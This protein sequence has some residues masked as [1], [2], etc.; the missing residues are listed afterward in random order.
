MPAAIVPILIAWGANAVVAYV[1]AYAITIVATAIISKALFSPSQPD[2]GG[3]GA[4]QAQ[5][6]P[7][8]RQQIPPATDNKLPVVYGDAYIGGITVDLSISSNNQELYYVL[9]L[10]EVTSTNTGQTPD[11]FT[12]G[13]VYYGGKKVN[14]QSDGYTVASLLDESTGTTDTAVAGKIQFYLYSN[15]SYAPVN[16]TINAVTVMSNSDLIYKWDSS[17]LMTNCAFAIIHLS[18]NNDAGITGIEQTRFEVKNPLKKPGDVI[19]DYL[20]NTR[21]GGAIPDDQIDTDSLDALNV[22][23]DELMT[24]TPYSGGSATQKRFEF[25]GTVV[26]TR[27][28]MQNLQDMTSCCDCL[29]KYNEIMGLWGVIVQSPSYVVSMDINDSNMIS[30]I[31]VSPVDIANSFNIAQVN[32]PDSANQDTF[33]SSTFDLAQIDPELLYPNE[34][35][36]QQ[37]ITLP[38]VNNDV[39]AQ[40][41]A[42]RFL[43]SAREDL[44]VQTS[45]NFVGIQLEA[46]DIVTLTNANYGWVAKLFRVG[47]V[48]ETFGDDGTVTAVLALLEFNPT[49]YDDVSITQFNPSPNTGLASPSF[50]GAIYVPV[51]S[52]IQS[53]AAIPSFDVNITTSTAGII[54]YAEVWYSAFSH[55][56][57]AQ[58]IF[59]G[60]TAIQS[61]GTPYNPSTLCPPVTLT[62]IPSGD[63]YFFTRM[64]NSLGT[65][66]YSN[67]STVLKWRPYTFQFSQQF[68][69]VAYANDIV[70]AGF[71]LNPR[72]KTFFGLS[73]QDTSTPNSDPSD[74]TWYPASPVFGT[75]VYLTFCNRTN[76]KMTFATG[77]AGYAAGTGQFV[78]SDT[79][80]FDPSLWSALADGTNFINLDTRTGQLIQTGTST[81]GTGEIYISNNSGG[82]IVGALKQYLNFGTGVYTKTAS[83]ATITVDI[84]G[85]IVGFQ[86]PDNFYYTE[87]QFTST[88][89]QTVFSVTRDADYIPYNCWVFQNGLLLDTAEYTD[90]LANVTLGTGVPAGDIISIIS[91]RSEDSTFTAYP[92]FTRFAADISNASS[93][94]ITGFTLNS[95][96]ELLFLNGTV[97]NEQDYNITGQQLNNFPATLTGLLTI[98]QWTANNLGTPVGN[99]VNIVQNTIIGQSAYSFSYDPAAI[100]IYG[101]GVLYEQGVDYTTGTGYYTLANTP[102]NI[103]NTMVQQTFTRQG[104]A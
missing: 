9:A 83:A 97:M 27:T 47:K 62:R 63:W 14:F 8:N 60:T 72:G 92:T 85:R 87:E 95:G 73:N 7:G 53:T 93:I 16:S 80:Q 76:R 88:A 21:Y 3:Y 79:T 82:Q 22:Y 44:Q 35:V 20:T 39:R 30:T 66:I 33:N 42:N 102:T 13:D 4:S 49:V 11:V 36:N 29:L 37:T 24:Y 55:P 67:A 90:T 43:K 68:L 40:Y 100:N 57:A 81:V 50:F 48:T 74:Y 52:N 5:P 86:T 41:L 59:A 54:Q 75:L 10:S 31:T 103:L 34:P 12:F 70:G 1:I 99:P 19:F 6:N 28:I 71:S 89:G 77:F 91:F 46:G 104:A 58:M 51:I 78:P 25:D 94:D 32:F 69:L 64:V 18:Y 61:N 17:K 15:G 26:T 56:T 23:S 38:Y 101:N 84:Y 45:I 96:F 65:S 98:I 2:M